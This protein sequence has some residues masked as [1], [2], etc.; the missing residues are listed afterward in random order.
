MAP[1][2]GEARLSSRRTSKRAAGAVLA[3]CL[4]GAAG[5]SGILSSSPH[6]SVGSNAAGGSSG[7]LSSDPARLSCQTSTDCVITC[8][9]DKA[10]CGELCECTDVV[11]RTWSREVRAWQQEHCDDVGCPVADCDVPEFD[12]EAV[13]VEGVCSVSKTPWTGAR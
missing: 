4:W 8:Q 13:C 10:C 9:P 6:T 1:D 2:L 7:A 11:S 5:C 3:V 12:Y